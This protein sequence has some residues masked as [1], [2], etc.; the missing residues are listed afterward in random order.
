MSLSD[1]E[2]KNAK[3]GAK[4]VKLSDGGGLQLWV[5]P[6]G[7][8]RWRLAY[9]IDGKQKALAIGV[10]PT[11]KV[12]EAREAREA[13]KKLIDAG[14]DPSIAK[15]IAKATRISLASSCPRASVITTFTP[16]RRARNAIAKTT[17]RFISRRRSKRTVCQTPVRGHPTP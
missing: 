6:D 15:K 13:A 1:L 4:V 10:Y 9:R 16:M 7:A 3:P 11:I 2:C 17:G 12:K 5:T 14:Q 8:K